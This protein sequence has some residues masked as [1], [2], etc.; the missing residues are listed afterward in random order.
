M[1]QTVDRVSAC[2]P[3]AWSCHLQ[4]YSMDFD[5]PGGNLHKT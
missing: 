4:N 5:S 2:V 3:S 1:Q